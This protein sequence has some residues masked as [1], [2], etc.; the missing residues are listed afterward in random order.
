MPNVIQLVGC[1]RFISRH[2]NSRACETPTLYPVKSAEIKER[3]PQFYLSIQSTFLNASS[4]PCEKAVKFRGGGDFLEEA[5]WMYYAVS[6][7]A[8]ETELL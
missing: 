6:D 1:L 7:V 4:M 8:N 2:S 3:R 5:Q